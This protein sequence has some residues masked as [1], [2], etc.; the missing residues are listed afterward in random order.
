M[1]LRWYSFDEIHTYFHHKPRQNA[2]GN[3]DGYK[4]VDT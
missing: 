1:R 4:I 2:G 3:N